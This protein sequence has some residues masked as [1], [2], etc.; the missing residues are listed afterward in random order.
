MLRVA[1]SPYTLPGC[2]SIL[3]VNRDLRFRSWDLRASAGVGSMIWRPRKVDK[4]PNNMTV[5]RSC[6][7]RPTIICILATWR[8]P[9]R[10]SAGSP[11]WCPCPSSRYPILSDLIISL[12][13]ELFDIWFFLLV[14]KFA[15]HLLEIKGVCCCYCVVLE[16]PF[17]SSRCH[18]SKLAM[19]IGHW[20]YH[21]VMS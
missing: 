3:V 11:L 2:W 1:R 5:R 10:R 9:C 15:P 14:V 8:S 18:C 13:R 20:E 6:S 12:E 16:W 17:F 21:L 19:P 7:K 4:P